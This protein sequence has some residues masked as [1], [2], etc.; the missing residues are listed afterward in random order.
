MSIGHGPAQTSD[1]TGRR[2]STID[3]NTYIST[4]TSIDEKRA[5]RSEPF[6]TDDALTRRSERYPSPFS[7][8]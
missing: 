4:D 7:K 5:R 8:P 2:I 3:K 1:P 6:L